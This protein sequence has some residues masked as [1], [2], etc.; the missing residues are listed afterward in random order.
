MTKEFVIYH[1]PRCSKSRQSLALLEE[2]SVSFK[3]KEY[4]KEPLSKNELEGI[5]QRLSISPQE[6]LRKK[7]AEYK[8]AAL[9]DDS[10]HESIV[11]AIIKY[12]KL[13]ER[14]VI[15]NGDSAVIGR[16]PEN[17]KKII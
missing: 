12:P 17:V 15:D 4:L 13:M 3:V 8:L 11:N 2:A 6:L 14:P 7:E 16:P 9:H 1:N 5:I 10:D